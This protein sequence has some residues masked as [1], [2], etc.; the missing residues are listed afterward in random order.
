MW[1]D[2]I[3]AIIS[4]FEHSS[5][6]ERTISISALGGECCTVLISFW[7]LCVTSHDVSC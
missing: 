7:R 6:L 4:S 3:L 2:T 5:S 1:Q